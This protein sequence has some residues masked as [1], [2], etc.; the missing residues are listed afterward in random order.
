MVVDSLLE[1]HEESLYGRCAVLEVSNRVVLLDRDGVLNVDRTDSV[2]SVEDLEVVTGAH[3]ATAALSSAG[4]RLL[5]VTNQ[6][7]VGRGLLDL[8]TL[9]SIH[10]ALDRRLGNTLDGFYVCP[11]TPEMGCAC[12][13]P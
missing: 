4:Y 13:K 6:S 9:H 12:R 11:H 2:K 7:V 8:D 1:F 10:H 3:E 5:V